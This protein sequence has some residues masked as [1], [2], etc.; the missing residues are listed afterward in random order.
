[1]VRSIKNPAGGRRDSIPAPRGK[2]CR[3]EEELSAELGADRLLHRS[4]LAIVDVEE[5]VRASQESL[6]APEVADVEEVHGELEAAVLRELEI[7]ADAQVDH[8]KRR[9]LELS[10]VARGEREAIR[11]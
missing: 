1:M 4:A 9:Q 5:L 11:R 6:K 8:V 7:A 3:S 10:L 2:A